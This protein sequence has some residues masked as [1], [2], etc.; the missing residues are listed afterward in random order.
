MHLSNAHWAIDFNNGLD[1]SPSP[2]PAVGNVFYISEASENQRNTPTHH[3]LL[4]EELKSTLPHGFLL[5]PM[6][7]YGFT[8]QCPRST[9]HYLLREFVPR[10]RFCS[11]FQGPH[12]NLFT[13]MTDDSVACSQGSSSGLAF[14]ISIHPSVYFKAGLVMCIM[15][16]SYN[17]IFLNSN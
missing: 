6:R 4:T 13:Q 9:C 1:S 11:L 17:P 10:R 14:Q 5:M 15:P 12:E 8:I 3:L 16:E 2:P 7:F